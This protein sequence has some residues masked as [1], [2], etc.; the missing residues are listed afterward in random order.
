MRRNCSVGHILF[1]KAHLRSNQNTAA[2]AFLT[3]LAVV[4]DAQKQGIG[5]KLI[6]RGL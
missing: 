3:P 4:P 6:A 2:I 5:G 1:T